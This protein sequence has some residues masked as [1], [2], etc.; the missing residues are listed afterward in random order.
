[1]PQALIAVK[2][3]W[4][5]DLF[6][7]CAAILKQSGAYT[8]IVNRWPP[9]GVNVRVWA[10]RVKAIADDWRKRYE[11]VDNDWPPE[12]D[13]WWSKVLSKRK[14][15][16][17]SVRKDADLLTALASLVS[18]A[19]EVAFRF[20]IPVAADKIHIIENEALA[21]LDDHTLC[22]YIHPSRA[23][24]LPKLH[25]SLA[26]MTIRSLTHNLALWERS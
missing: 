22:R 26:G 3:A 20:G 15:D 24:V 14:K 8:E 17:T 1:M 18:A 6:A 2:P 19:D 21:H 23:R 13:A 4:P 9:G 10:E 16:L 25:N 5:P 11:S 12:V 7:L